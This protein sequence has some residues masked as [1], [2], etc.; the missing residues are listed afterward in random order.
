MLSKAKTGVAVLALPVNIDAPFS[1]VC[2]ETVLPAAALLMK[3]VVVLTALNPVPAA[4]VNPEAA[5]P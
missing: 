3:P 2:T 5:E 1:Q 4:G